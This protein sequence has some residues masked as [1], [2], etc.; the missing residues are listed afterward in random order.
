MK[1]ETKND[2]FFTMKIQNTMLNTYLGQKGYTILKTELSVQEQH[3]I[4]EE[5]TIKPY[6][7]GSPANNAAVTFP[8]Y[9]RSF[10]FRDTL[11]RRCLDP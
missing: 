10:M 11:A 8:A 7:P 6:V 9:R 3:V 1:I 4:R 5:L 2:D